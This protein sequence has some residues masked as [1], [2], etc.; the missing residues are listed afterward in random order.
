MKVF[1]ILL[2]VLALAIAALAQ[3][4]T[5][6]SVSG[7]K[8]TVTG[9]PGAG[10]VDLKNTKADK[11]F[12]FSLI[13]IR[14]VSQAGAVLPTYNSFNNAGF[15]TSKNDD[16]TYANLA[17]GLIDLNANGI[18]VAISSNSTADANVNIKV[19]VLKNANAT[20]VSINS[21]TFNLAD[22]WAV[23]EVALTNWPVISTESKLYID[24]Q[25]KTPGKGGMISSTGV[26]RLYDGIYAQT[27]QGAGASTTQTISGTTASFTYTYANSSTNAN[28][29]FVFNV[30]EEAD[31]SPASTLTSF[32]S[33]LF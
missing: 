31:P 12:Q 17:A 2:V 26:A 19:H 9:N 6:V 22:G 23:V 32:L 18:K 30:A 21:K 13:R 28:A 29:V 14:E 3:A 1:A 7:T 10:R 8:L 27:A 20:A 25:I 24:A 16:A 4:P 15:T 11:T 33:F 5:P